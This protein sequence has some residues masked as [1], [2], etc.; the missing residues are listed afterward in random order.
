MCWEDFGAVHFWAASLLAIFVWYLGVDF[1][2][3][4]VLWSLFR[5]LVCFLVFSLSGRFGALR[6][7]IFI[8]LVCQRKKKRKKKKEERKKRAWHPH[9]L[10]AHKMETPPTSG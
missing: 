3:F 10:I 2:F 8:F 7:N 5:V 1:V 6:L 4:G 9:G